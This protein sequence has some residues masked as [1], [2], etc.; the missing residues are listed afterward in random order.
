MTFTADGVDEQLDGGLDGGAA[1]GGLDPVIFIVLGAL[2]I[3]M[4]LVLDTRLV[5][6]KGKQKSYLT[7][8]MAI[9]FV[10]LDVLLARGDA[11]AAG[12]DG[13]ERA[14]VRARRRRHRRLGRRRAG[15]AVLFGPKAPKKS[16]AAKR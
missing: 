3:L 4:A 6:L 11:V 16:A 8:A 15:A 1:P 5:D 9:A 2:A 7:A 13:G 12:Q 10:V 14:V